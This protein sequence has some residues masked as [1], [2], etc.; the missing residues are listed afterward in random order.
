MAQVTIYLDDETLSRMKAAAK[1]AGVSMSAWLTGLVQ[2][3]V[4]R[5]W[6]EEVTQLAGAW[7]DFPDAE[8][9]RGGFPNDLPRETL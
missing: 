2:E 3:K 1:S 9:I 6:P 7:R 4:R 8:E 5:D